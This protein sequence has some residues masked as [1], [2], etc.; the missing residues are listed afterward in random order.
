MEKWNQNIG[1]CVYS[2]WTEDYILNAK[3]PVCIQMCVKINQYL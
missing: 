1:V 3:S 2:E